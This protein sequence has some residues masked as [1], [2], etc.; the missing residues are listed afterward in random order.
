MVSICVVYQKV[1]PL[2]RQF[3]TPCYISSRPRKVPIKKL[4]II[5]CP[6]IPNLAILMARTSPNQNAFSSCVMWLTFC[7]VSLSSGDQCV[8]AIKPDQ[9]NNPTPNLLNNA[10]SVFC[11]G[12]KTLSR[13]FWKREY[14]GYCA[15]VF[16]VNFS[17]IHLCCA[18]CCVYSVVYLDR[19]IYSCQQWIQ[20]LQC[21]WG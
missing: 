8:F 10:N 14:S 7:L 1:I 15:N 4:W 13:R 21:W 12:C 2:Y 3:S 20:S 11:S 17:N 5:P 16:P 6:E 9:Q 19:I 18:Y